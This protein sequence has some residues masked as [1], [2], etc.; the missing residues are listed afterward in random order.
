MHRLRC[1]EPKSGPIFATSLGT[2]ISMDNL[3]N[4]KMR[5]ILDVCKHCGLANGKAHVHAK[6]PHRFEV[7]DEDTLALDS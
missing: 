7:P 3:L 1:G 5:P 4:R 2:R 6:K